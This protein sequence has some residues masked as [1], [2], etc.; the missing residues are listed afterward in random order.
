MAGVYAC[1]PLHQSLRRARPKGS[2]PR[3]LLPDVDLCRAYFREIV[4]GIVMRKYMFICM[5]AYFARMARKASQVCY[6]SD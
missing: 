1:R 6:H 2:P 3:L 4:L 5:L